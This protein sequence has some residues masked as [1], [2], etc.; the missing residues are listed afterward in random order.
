[1]FFYVPPVFL[2]SA[3]HEF[4]LGILGVF[5]PLKLEKRDQKKGIRNNLNNIDF[6][7]F[8]IYFRLNILCLLLKYIAESIKKPD[9]KKTSKF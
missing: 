3:T 5:F 6:K 7:P 9:E 2:S 1:M 4:W 8:F